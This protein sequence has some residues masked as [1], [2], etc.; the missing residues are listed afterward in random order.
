MKFGRLTVLSEEKRGYKVFYWCKCSC[1]NHKWIM[2]QS[3]RKGAT[4]SCGCLQREASAARKLPPQT[5]F[6][7]KWIP[8]PFS[9]CW[10]W[11]AHCHR[12]TGYP[13]IR[14]KKGTSYA[15]RVAYELY[16]GPIPV[17][18]TID[19]LCRTKSCVNP[20]HLEAVSLKENI[21]RGD[22]SSAVNKRKTH[23]KRGHA[24]TE[25]NIYQHHWL[26]YGWR[27]CIAC[28]RERAE[29]TN[30]KRKSQKCLLH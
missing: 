2:R 12:K 4:R 10:L 7:K 30:E 17:G 27:N 24:L 14:F 5:R 29:I 1:G 19:H 21:L 9:G 6:D 26:K 15:H 11:T 18:L 28:N 13:E 8:E 3:L 20:S 25:N 23:C 16:V 22:S